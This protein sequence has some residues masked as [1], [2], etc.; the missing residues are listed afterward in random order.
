MKFCFLKITKIPENFVKQCPKLLNSVSFDISTIIS[1]GLLAVPWLHKR[2]LFL[3]DIWL[4]INYNFEKIY[5]L[6]T[7]PGIW[8]KNLFDSSY[9]K[10]L[11]KAW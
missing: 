5:A 1:S 6:Q 4:F 8:A 3:A 9:W 10:F 7:K 2:C 11:L